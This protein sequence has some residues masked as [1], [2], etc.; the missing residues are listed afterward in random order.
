MITIKSEYNNGVLGLFNQQLCASPRRLAVVDSF[1]DALTYDQLWGSA[2]AVA[3]ALRDHGVKGSDVVPLFAG[4]T[5]KA[6]AAIFGIWEAGGAVMPLDA[7]WPRLRLERQVGIAGARIG[8]RADVSAPQVDLPLIDSSRVHPDAGGPRAPRVTAPAEV[9]YVIPT[10]GSTGEPK[11][12]LNSHGAMC[13]LVGAL[14]E[15]ILGRYGAGL[16]TAVV[17]AWSFDPWVQQ[18]CPALARGDTLFLVDDDARRDGRLLARFYREHQIQ[19]SDGTPS[20][21][22]LLALAGARGLESLPV[23]HFIIG[24]ERMQSVDM[25]DLFT[26]YPTSDFRI[27][28]IYGVAECAVDSLAF[29][30]TRETLPS[31]VTVPVGRPLGRTAVLI[32]DSQGGEADQ[33]QAGELYLGGL[34]LGLGYLGNRPETE[35][36]FISRGGQLWYRTG[37]QALRL[38]DGNIEILGRLD[39]QV[40]I[41]GKR[42]ELGEIESV[43]RAFTPAY[44]SPGNKAGCPPPPPTC[45]RCVLTSAHPGLSFDADGFC[46]ICRDYD[47]WEPHLRRYWRTRDD[48]GRLADRIRRTGVGDIDCLLQFSGGKDSS[49]VA[50]RLREAGLRVLCWTFDNGFISDAAFANIERTTRA[51][52]MPSVVERTEKMNEIFCQSLRTRDTVCDGC[53]RALTTLS[54]RFAAEHG[55]PLVVSGLSRGQIL[56]TKLAPLLAKGIIEAGEIDRQ[57]VEHRKISEAKH[58]LTAELL[59]VSVE[60][61]T[62]DTLG[63][64]DYFRFEEVSD[65][66][67]LEF[68]RSRDAVWNLPGN[69]GFCSTN[70]R[71]NDVGIRV[72]MAARGYHNYAGP[73]SWEI[74]M[75]Q[76]SRED[77]AKKLQVGGEIEDTRNILSEIGYE[78]RVTGAAVTMIDGQLVA[79]YTCEGDVGQTALRSHLRLHLPDYAV[80]TELHQVEAFPLNSSGK[81]DVHALRETHRQQPR[82]AASLPLE[83]D[84][85]RGLAGC[86]QDVLHDEP[87]NVNES[88]LDKGDSLNVM[89]LAVAI[90]QRFA[91]VLPFAVIATHPTFGELSREIESRLQSG[92]SD[93]LVLTPGGL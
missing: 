53:F 16:R 59:G 55:I 52:G 7:N 76:L 57:L 47:R 43:I 63:F 80:P 5:C 32:A 46:N 51:L 67:I 70:C 58:D 33:T 66:E 74:R 24:G 26:R 77:T 89:E 69:T 4:R 3:S 21:C 65:S 90:E 71:I 78:P 48:F 11:L 30:F 13:H 6:I 42:V 10:S 31:A 84:I 1:G 28:N 15:A 27:T 61:R 40:K 39:N 44:L 29:T 83:S 64:V 87:R 41:N 82:E 85:D 91:I 88:F 56:E 36:K 23:C 2:K 54:S 18:V 73:L 14:E 45:R 20:H 9:A 37:D 8:V 79:F 38:P 62:I 19:I 17:A 68:L 50:H 60:G 35:K 81:V 72:H 25:R 34:G 86:W 12:A 49:F 22:R 92:L 75:G 93:G